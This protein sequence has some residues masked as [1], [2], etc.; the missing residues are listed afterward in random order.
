SER[1]TPR[2]GLRPVLVA[3]LLAFATLIRDPRPYWLPV[4]AARTA[5]ADLLATVRALPGSVY[6]P[7]IGQFVSGPTLYPA[8]HWIAVEDIMRGPRRTAADSALARQLIDSARHPSG[9]AFMLTNRP[10]A[11]LSAPVRE[12]APS[13]TLVQDFGNRFAAL[14]PLPRPFDT[15][16]PRYLYRSSS[17]GASGSG[18]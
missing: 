1:V 3:A 17:D 15:G 18:H 14:E 4:A 13:Y 7:G 12:L 9:V 5:Y 6:A 11:S 8:A 2:F 16:F 10:I